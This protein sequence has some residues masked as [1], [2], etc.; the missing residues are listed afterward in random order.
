MIIIIVII[1]PTSSPRAMMSPS[2]RSGTPGAGC[3][4]QRRQVVQ[5]VNLDQRHAFCHQSRPGHRG[6]KRPRGSPP[7]A[8]CCSRCGYDQWQR[9]VATIDDD[10]NDGDNNV[11]DVDNNDDDENNDDDDNH[12]KGEN[13]LSCLTMMIIVMMMRMVRTTRLMVSL[14]PASIKSSVWL[15]SV[16][17]S[18]SCS[19]SYK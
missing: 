13:R 1:T 19:S 6:P 8:S 18:W 14:L 11:D 15:T 9:S 4:S 5:P 7:T 17:S 10:E 2:G 12:E 3:C 16:A